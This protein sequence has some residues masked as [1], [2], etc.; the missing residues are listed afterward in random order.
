MPS[1]VVG[2]NESSVDLKSITRRQKMKKLFG[3]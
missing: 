2:A 1:L 3:W